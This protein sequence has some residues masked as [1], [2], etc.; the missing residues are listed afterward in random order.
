MIFS[1]N[2]NPNGVFVLLWKLLLKI[3]MQTAN[4]IV[5]ETLNHFG[6][7]KLLIE[8]STRIQ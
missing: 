2:S 1:L 7:H 4:T 6:R 8:Y 3:N 5:F